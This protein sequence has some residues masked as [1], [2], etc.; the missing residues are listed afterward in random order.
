MAGKPSKPE[1]ELRRIQLNQHYGQHGTVTFS[2]LQAL[3]ANQVARASLTALCRSTTCASTTSSATS[4]TSSRYGPTSRLNLGARYTVFQLFHEAHG[5]ANPFDFDTCGPQG[6]CGLGASFGQQNYGDFD[7]RVG[8][9]WS[10]EQERKDDRSRRIRDVP[11]RRPAG[12]SES[13]RQERS[14]LL[15]SEPR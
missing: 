8:L 13:A 4:R 7:P 14:P 12:R 5:K 3:A 11:R 6:F 10:P 15:L 2:T 9:A 1:R